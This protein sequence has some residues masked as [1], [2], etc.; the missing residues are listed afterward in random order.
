MKDPGALDRQKSPLDFL[1]GEGKQ[2][3]ACTRCPLRADN[4]HTSELRS[5]FSDVHAAGENRLD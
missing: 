2:L 5:V 1:D 4:S 3:R